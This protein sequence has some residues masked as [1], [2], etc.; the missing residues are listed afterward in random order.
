MLSNSLP[1]SQDLKQVIYLCLGG[2]PSSTKR[3]RTPSCLSSSQGAVVD[4][5]PGPSITSRDCPRG[6]LLLLLEEGSREM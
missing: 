6:S 1:S 3:G 4:T 2:S 5:S